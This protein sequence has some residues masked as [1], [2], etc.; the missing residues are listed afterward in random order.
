MF[1]TGSTDFITIIKST[2]YFQI[3][4]YKNHK[5]QPEEPNPLRNELSLSYFERIIQLNGIFVEVHS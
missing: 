3:K 1:L 5:M 2:F 4:K